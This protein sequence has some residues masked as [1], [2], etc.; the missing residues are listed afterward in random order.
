MLRWLTLHSLGRGLRWCSVGPGSRYASLRAGPEEPCGDGPSQNNTWVGSMVSRVHT[1]GA[2]WCSTR[3][4]LCCQVVAIRAAPREGG[5]GCVVVLPAEHRSL[6]HG[7]CHRGHRVG[8]CRLGAAGLQPPDNEGR[9]QGQS[10]AGLCRLALGKHARSDHRLSDQPAVLPAPRIPDGRH[11][12]TL[13]STRNR[14]RRAVL[15]WPM[16]RSGN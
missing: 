15:D 12:G 7:R 16:I 14:L 3:A 11:R 9:C 2:R 1:K 6:R 10:T 8:R 13:R 4:P 5:S